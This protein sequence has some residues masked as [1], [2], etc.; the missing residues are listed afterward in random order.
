MNEVIV[1]SITTTIKSIEKDI[2]YPGKF[3]F[4]CN[5]NACDTISLNG[6]FEKQ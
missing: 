4:K 2:L 1:S 6:Q 5:G 3:D